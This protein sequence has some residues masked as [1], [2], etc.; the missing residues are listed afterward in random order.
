MPTFVTNDTALA[1]DL[2][3]AVMRLVRRLRSQRS[4]SSLTLTQLSAL[5]A[6]DRH[7]S[8]TPGEL[9]GHEKVQPPSMT[10]VIAEL[11]ARGLVERQP[12]P[13]DRRQSLVTIAPAGRALLAEDRRRRE[14]WLDRQLRGLSAE[15]RD[16]LRIAAPILERLAGA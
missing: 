2:R 1:H 5:S 3:I 14:A 16:I 4:D 10:R 8:L 11:Q 15:E 9:A 7:G 12:H 6:L 13:R